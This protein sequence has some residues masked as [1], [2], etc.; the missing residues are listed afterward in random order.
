MGDIRAF[1][2]L[3]P[4][5]RPS[6]ARNLPCGSSVISI[7]AISKVTFLMWCILFVL[8]WPLALLSLVLYPVV[9]LML[10]CWTYCF[11]CAASLSFSFDISK[12]SLSGTRSWGIRTVH[13]CV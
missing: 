8:C 1:R 12:M 11:M 7:S 5:A 2:K 10:L 3:L 4:T 6:S 13:G 9:W